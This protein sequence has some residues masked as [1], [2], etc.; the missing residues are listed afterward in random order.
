MLAAPVELRF[1]YE[2]TDLTLTLNA[3]PAVRFVGA[4]FFPAATPGATTSPGITNCNIVIGAVATEMAELVSPLY[5]APVSET[6]IA[7]LAGP[8]VWLVETL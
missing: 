3:L 1:Q 2:S 6:V 7:R 5:V 8:L 4:P